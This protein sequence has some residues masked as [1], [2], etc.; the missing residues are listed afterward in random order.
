M[1]G[2]SRMR[3]EPMAVFTTLRT[4]HSDVSSA[5][6]TDQSLGGGACAV[7][8]HGGGDELGPGSHSRL[9]AV[10]ERAPQRVG[11]W[12]AGCVLGADAEVVYSLCPVVLIVDLGDD[13]LGCAGERGGGCSARAAV[14]D[15][16]RDPLEKSLLVD[17]TDGQAVGVV[18]QQ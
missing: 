18:V 14:V 9:E 7:V 3:R 15:D 8:A 6:G 4:Q 10:L 16:C 5:V 1:S 11:G 17:L 13:D 2:H 12:R